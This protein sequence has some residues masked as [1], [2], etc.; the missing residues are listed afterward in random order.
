MVIHTLCIPPSMAKHGYGTQMVD[1]AKN[2]AA[3]RGCQVIRID[4]YA[5]NEPAKNLYLKNNFQI[6]AYGKM[7]LQGLIEEDQVYLEIKL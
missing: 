6:A 4:T 7:K 2:L 1:F 5:H 3:E